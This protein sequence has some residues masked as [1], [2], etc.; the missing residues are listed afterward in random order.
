M[1][2]YGIILQSEAS[3][4]RPVDQQTLY[5]V[6]NFFSKVI[7]SHQLA[8]DILLQL[9]YCGTS[10]RIDVSVESPFQ[11]SAYSSASEECGLAAT[12]PEEKKISAIQ[13][14][15]QRVVWFYN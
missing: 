9:W 11:A 4:F 10:L 2:R 12:S 5:H 6:S 8:G 7:N 13:P 15:C 14:I 1:K 3:F